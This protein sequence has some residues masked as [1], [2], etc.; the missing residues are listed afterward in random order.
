MFSPLSSDSPANTE[1]GKFT[2][3]SALT[4]KEGG[5]GKKILSIVVSITSLSLSLS[6]TYIKP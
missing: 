5:G 3:D 2:T 1:A 4:N 6:L